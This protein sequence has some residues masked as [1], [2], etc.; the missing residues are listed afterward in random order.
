MSGKIQKVHSVGYRM[1]QVSVISPTKQFTFEK[2]SSHANI[3]RK[4][5]GLRKTVTKI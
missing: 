3:V 2:I 5:F 4:I 1:H